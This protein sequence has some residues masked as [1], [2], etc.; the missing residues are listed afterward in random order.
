MYVFECSKLK[1]FRTKYLA[2]AYAARSYSNQ[3]LN[4][5]GSYH[6]RTLIILTIFGMFLIYFMICCGNND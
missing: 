2:S 4:L 3:M 1:S 5:L 6:H